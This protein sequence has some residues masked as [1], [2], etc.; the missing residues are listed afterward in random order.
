MKTGVRLTVAMA[1]AGVVLGL[2]WAWLAPPIHSAA[3]VTKSGKRI[4]QYLG[5]EADHYFDAA[6]LLAGLLVGLGVVV[7]VLVWQW[8]QQRGPA[9]VVWL[10]V[11]GMA[12]AAAAAGVGAGLVRIRYGHFD[13]DAVP[14]D[15][16]LHYVTQAPA[17][18]FGHSPLQVLTVLL[19]PAVAAILTY[20]MMAAASAHDDLGVGPSG[21][22]SVAETAPQCSSTT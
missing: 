14:D 19:L 4:Q 12:A 11:G 9:M 10:T 3:A 7:A 18:F 2:L 16:K 13:I 1:A 21:D 8:R 15:H 20:A 17:V 6:V 5:N 22:A